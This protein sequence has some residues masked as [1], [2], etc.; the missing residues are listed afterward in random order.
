MGGL[1]ICVG[2]SLGF[3]FWLLI[4]LV[5]GG[6]GLFVSAGCCVWFVL[7]MMILIAIGVCGCC[8]WFAMLALVC[9][10]FIVAMVWV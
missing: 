3:M 8:V 2:L 6:A 4:D 9:G 5:P 10:W 1:V 7:M